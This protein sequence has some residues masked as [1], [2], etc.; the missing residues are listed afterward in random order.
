MLKEGVSDIIKDAGLVS[1][2]SSKGE[3]ASGK[4]PV[5]LLE[6]ADPIT[7]LGRCTAYA[8]VGSTTQS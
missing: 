7:K 8:L 1:T 5:A 2:L 3:S 4:G 6:C